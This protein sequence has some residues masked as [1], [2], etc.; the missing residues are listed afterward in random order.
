MNLQ[1][2]PRLRDESYL[3]WVA[4]RPCCGCQAFPPNHAHHLRGIGKFGGAGLKPPDYLAMPLC[5]RCHSDIHQG[6]IALALQYDWVAH[7]L[8]AAFKE[9]VVT[10][11]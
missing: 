5:L 11:G 8:D 6:R 2:T 10:F 3:R 1:K 7:T 9:G 4:M